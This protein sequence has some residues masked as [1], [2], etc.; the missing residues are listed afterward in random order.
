MYLMV[1]MLNFMHKL[2][3]PLY[4]CILFEHTNP[5]LW[6]RCS[7]VKLTW[8]LVIRNPWHPNK[9]YGRISIA[10]WSFARDLVEVE[11][12]F[13]HEKWFCN[14]Y[15][16]MLSHFGKF[17]KISKYKVN[18]GKSFRKYFQKRSRRRKNGLKRVYNEGVMN[19]SILTTKTIFRKNTCWWTFFVGQK[20]TLDVTR[21]SLAFQNILLHTKT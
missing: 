5:R 14:K 13:G 9:V 12:S 1:F 2:V 8:L 19:F 15:I 17:W 21:R 3:I 7:F 6:F 11:T 10:L 18:F 20:E 4:F 16:Y